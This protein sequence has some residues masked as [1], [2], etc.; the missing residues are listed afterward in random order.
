LQPDNP[1]ARNIERFR[2][3]RSDGTFMQ[4]LTHCSAC[5]PHAALQCVT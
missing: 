4:T 1:S 5:W 2:C 3:K